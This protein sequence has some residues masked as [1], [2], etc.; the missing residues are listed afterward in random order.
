[1]LEHPSISHACVVGLQ[2]KRYGE[3]VGAFLQLRPGSSKLSLDAVRDW[4]KH[5]LG[6]HK[7]PAYVFWVGPLEKIQE[8]P[9]TGNGKYRKAV[10][11]EL[12]NKLAP[13]TAQPA[14]AKL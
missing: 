4:V 8:Y 6:R 1:M 9:L 11:R 3:V 2:D 12:G 7:A 10:L 14:V 13:G 5:H